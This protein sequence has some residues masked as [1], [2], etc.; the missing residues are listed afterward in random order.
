M[1][2]RTLLFL[3]LLGALALALSACGGE[4]PDTVARPVVRLQVNDQLFEENTY[5]YCWPESADN[6]ECDLDAVALVQ[7]LRNVPVGEGDAVQFVLDGGAG[8]PSRFTATLLGFDDVRDLGTGTVAEY[9]IALEDNLYRVRVDAEYDDVEGHPAYVSYVFGL[10]VAGVVA[11]TPTPMPLPTETP[12]PTPTLAPTLTPQPTS[13]PL[14]SPTAEPTPA[15]EPTATPTP[16][17]EAAE[18]EEPPEPEGETAAETAVA[19]AETPAPEPAAAEGVGALLLVGTVRV[20]DRGVTLP[21]VGATVYY[22]HESTIAPEETVSGATLTGGQGQFNIGPLTLRETDSLTI[23]AFAP[24]Y[25]TQVL[26]L[27]GDETWASGGVIEFVLVPAPSPARE[28]GVALLP[29][30]GA[31]APGP[32]PLLNL[33]VAGRA[34]IP[35]GLRF[36]QQPADG[37]PSCVELPAP[38]SP[39]ERL[40]LLRGSTAQL[41]IGGGRP[42]SVRIEYLTDTGIPTG[43]PENRPG[44]NMIL[45]IV[46]PEPGSYIMAVQVVWSGYE[47]TYFFRV[48]VSD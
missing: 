48:S 16:S 44:D 34:H 42:S 41:R 24:G 36:C 12:L 9:P 2:T 46:T 10:A 33:I 20:S 45:F 7:P 27:T 43:Q 26:E 37:A 15:P 17:P 11:P 30:I 5:S 4:E 40:S 14:P 25:E 28:A 6:L 47:A 18:D 21:V 23:K 32:V 1:K 29:G 8:A 3:M 35:V 31:A 39:T 13:T 38:D 19:P 22:V